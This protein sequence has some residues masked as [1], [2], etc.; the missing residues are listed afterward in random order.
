MGDSL[1]PDCLGVCRSIIEEHPELGVLWFGFRYERP[2]GTA[3]G[4]HRFASE[5][6]LD[7][8]TVVTRCLR[9]GNFFGGPVNVLYRRA[10]FQA[11]GGHQTSLPWLA[12]FDL[13]ARLAMQV[14]AWT[15]ARMLGNFPPA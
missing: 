8:A 9:E 2:D 10:A 14:P 7:A 1:E 15:T 13:Y 4:E 12:D 5:G 3:N 6:R 11:T